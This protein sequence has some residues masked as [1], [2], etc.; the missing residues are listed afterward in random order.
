MRRLLKSLIANLHEY[1]T[2]YFNKWHNRIFR[3]AGAL[4]QIQ[5][6]GLYHLFVYF[7]AFS[8]YCAIF[9]LLYWVYFE[10][11][12]FFFL[13]GLGYRDLDY[14]KFD[15]SEWFGNIITVKFW[16]LHRLIV[17]VLTVMSFPQFFK[18]AS[19]SINAFFGWQLIYEFPRKSSWREQ[20]W[21][22]W[23]VLKY[24]TEIGVLLHVF[25]WLTAYGVNPPCTFVDFSVFQMYYVFDWRCCTMHPFVE[26]S[27]QLGPDTEYE[28][29]E[30][31][32]YTRTMALY[33]GGRLLYNLQPFFNIGVWGFS[34]APYVPYSSEYNIRRFIIFWWIHAASLLYIILS[35]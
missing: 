26:I 29:T 5:N 33:V 2:S 7:F 11:V 4:Y 9:S 27:V 14:E 31:E 22:G 28:T 21:I 17:H 13:R 34:S 25:V 10:W 15:Y 18:F 35:N 16:N 8:I 12:S 30:G 24:S 3:F 32:I 19:F 23:W 20:V 1:K 6:Y